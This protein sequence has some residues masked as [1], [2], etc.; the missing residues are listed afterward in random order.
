MYRIDI[1]KNVHIHYDRFD[2]ILNPILHLLFD[3]FYQGILGAH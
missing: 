3:T 1:K 2:V